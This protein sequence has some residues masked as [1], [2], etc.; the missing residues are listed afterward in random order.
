MIETILTGGGTGG[1][2]VALAFAYQQ[3]QASRRDKRTAPAEANSAAVTDAAA[4]NSLLLASLR[5]EREETQRLSGRIEDLETQ[6][7]LLYERMRDQRRE[8]ER[9]IAQLRRQVDSVQD[10]LSQF[11]TKLRRDDAPG[12]SQ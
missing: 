4:A 1:M 8:Y 3:Y 9:E 2:V 6:N 5:E 7:A 11:E 10:Q 12:G